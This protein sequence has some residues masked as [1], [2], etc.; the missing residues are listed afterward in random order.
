MNKISKRFIGKS[1]ITDNYRENIQA[2]SSEQCLWVRY[3]TMLEY[4]Q[5]GSNK[6]YKLGV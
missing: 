5:V 2:K 3:C 6:R 4:H 1:I